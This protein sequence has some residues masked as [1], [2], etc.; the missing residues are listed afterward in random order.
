MN[1]VLWDNSQFNPWLKVF[2]EL[3]VETT[4]VERVGQAEV[5]GGHNHTIYDI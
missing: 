2:V 1:I 3:E 5:I 4:L